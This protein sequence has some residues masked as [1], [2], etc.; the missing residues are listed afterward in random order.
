[1]ARVAVIGAG[2]TI[3]S[4]GADPFDVQDYVVHKRMGDAATM[5]ETY[6]E[7]A[8]LADLVP[9]AFPPV[10]STEFDFAQCR[11]LVLEIARLSAAGDVDGVVILHGTATMEETAYF[12]S[13]TVP[14]GFPVAITGAQRP[15][16]GL[17]ADGGANIAAAVRTVLAP[18]ARQI[19]VLLVMNEEIHAPRDVT[20]TS[21][22]RLQTFRTPDFGALGHADA[23]AVVFYRKPLRSPPHFDITTVE[24]AP[25]VDIAYAYQ[26]ADGVAIDAFVAAAAKGI[27]VAA[28]APGMLPPAQLAALGEASRAGVVCVAASRAGSGRVVALQRLADAG[29]IPADNLSAQKAR[30]LLRLGLLSSRTAEEMASLFLTH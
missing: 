27:V 23:D 26:G 30:I 24:S 3:S 16:T 14:P 13:L 29:V 22:W 1:M 20:K 11:A 21:N 15:A 17:S 12:L 25:R 6:S 9:I 18:E 10:A 7:V 19:G 8:A 5:L 4:F 28:L 2:G